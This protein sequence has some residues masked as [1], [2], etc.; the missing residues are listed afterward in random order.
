MKNKLFLFFITFVYFPVMIF[1]AETGELD[2]TTRSIYKANAF[3]HKGQYHEALSELNH[4]IAKNEKSARAHKVRG[5]VYIAMGELQQALNDLN[6][7]V[8]LAPNSA[9][10][11]VDRSIVYYKLGNRT[12]AIKDIN[13]ALQLSPNSSFAQGVKEKITTE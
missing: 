4:A 10:P 8:E 6:R 7:V 5:H 9:T 13:R 11:Y 1:T 12:Q 3:A 2:T